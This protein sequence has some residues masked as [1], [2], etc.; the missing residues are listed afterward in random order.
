[1]ALAIDSQMPTAT[2][3][4]ITNNTVLT[5]SFTNTAGTF[6]LVGLGWGNSAVASLVISSVT[7]NGVG[8]T[9][10]VSVGYD[11]AAH[12]QSGTAIASLLN[13]ATGANNVVVTLTGS[14]SSL[15]A[16]HSGA[17]SFTGNDTSTPVVASSGKTNF[18]ESAGTTA[19]VTSGTTTSGNI[20]VAQMAAGS[21]YS[22]TSQTLSWSKN[23]NTNSAG[24]NGAMTYANGTGGAIAFSNTIGS[25]FMGMV[26]LEVAAA[27]GGASRGLF[28]TPSLSGVGVGGSFFRDPLQ[29]PMQMV[30]RDRI[31]V[32]ARLAA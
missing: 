13:P 31:F 32:P 8:M 30:R 28:R 21:G 18:R 10:S 12:N 1:M 29:A 26:C 4:S 20:A 24:G 23:V 14:I 25:D 7:Y 16:I 5:Y 3:A 15:T 27:S 6:L 9:V 17:M 19:T 22:A 11:G 2:G